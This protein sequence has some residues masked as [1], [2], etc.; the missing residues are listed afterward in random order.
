M[1]FEGSL[2][3]SQEPVTGPY[4]EPHESSPYHHIISLLDPH[5]LTSHLRLGAFIMNGACTDQIL[6]VVFNFT[7]YS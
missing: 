2:P 7:H 4:S 6:L 1:E 3:S 5:L